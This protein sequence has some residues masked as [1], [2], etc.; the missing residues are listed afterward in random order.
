MHA[1]SRFVDFIIG[2]EG[3]A[4][5]LAAGSRGDSYGLY[6]DGEGNCTD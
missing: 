1:S 4:G 2:Y 5:M 6:N 3:N